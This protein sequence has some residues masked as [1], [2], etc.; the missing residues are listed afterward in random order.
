MG[1][2]SSSSPP[3][4][5]THLLAEAIASRARS[6]GYTVDLG[7]AAAG[8]L[9]PPEA[10]DAVVL[11]FDLGSQTGAA[12]RYVASHRTGL[13]Q[14]PTALF[15]VSTPGSA[16][17]GDPDDGVERFLRSARWRPDL[18]AAFAGARS[19]PRDGVLV[20]VGRELGYL[21]PAVSRAPT[22]TDWSEVKRFGDAVAM[23]LAATLDEDRAGPQFLGGEASLGSHPG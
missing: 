2:S 8:G 3:H 12:A 4:R 11:G 20:H 13:A 1:G 5:S 17:D 21:P 16:G 15:M 18:T 6:H 10:Y 14:V 7:D 22:S 19:F 23:Q 9:P